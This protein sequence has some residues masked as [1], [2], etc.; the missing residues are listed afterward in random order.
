MAER[1]NSS[2]VFGGISFY[3]ALFLTFMVLKLTE[4]IDW[5]WWWVTSPLWGGVAALAAFIL[6]ALA[7]TA[8]LAVAMGIWLKWKIYRVA[9]AYKKKLDAELNFIK[10]KDE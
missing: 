1:N 2:N 9:R 6:I 8:I 10:E 3:G 4:V 5:S 7:G